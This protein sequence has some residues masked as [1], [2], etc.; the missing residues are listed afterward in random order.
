MVVDAIPAADGI[1]DGV[2][3]NEQAGLGFVLPLA[4]FV[5]CVFRSSMG[6]ARYAAVV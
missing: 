6:L 1:C 2:L 3:G 5:A 4:L